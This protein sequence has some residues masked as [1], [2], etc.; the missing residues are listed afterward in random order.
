MKLSSILFPGGIYLF[1]GNNKQARQQY[2]TVPKLTK[3]DTRT[4]SF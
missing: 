4:M 2:D 3:K 1:K